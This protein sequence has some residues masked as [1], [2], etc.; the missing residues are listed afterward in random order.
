M[1]R[2]FTKHCGTLTQ[3]RVGQLYLGEIIGQLF[4]EEVTADPVVREKP[5]P[6]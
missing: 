3:V 2:L 6:P 5:L 1:I 4:T